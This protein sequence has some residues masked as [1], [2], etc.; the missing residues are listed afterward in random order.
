MKILKY[1]GLSCILL[2]TI[3][4]CKNWL[5][6]NTDPDNP[7]NA[8]ASLSNRLPWVQKFWQYTAGPTNFR[9]AMIAGVYYS[10]S[11]AT[12]SFGITWNCDPGSIVV[13]SYQTWFVEVASNLNDMYNKAEAEGAYHYMAASNVIHALGFMQMLDLFGEMPYTE[14]LG[15]SASPAYDDGKTIFYGCI[16]K[17]DEAIELLGRTQETGATQLSAGD[18]WGGGNTSKWIKFCYGLKARFLLKLSKKT[19]LFDANAILDCLA[20]GPQSNADNI[21]GLCYNVDGDDNDYFLSDPVNTNGNWNFA[22]YG[23]NQRISKYYYDLLTNMRGS[24]VEDPRMTKIV[25]ATMGNIKLNANGGLQSYDWI[26]SEPV[27]FYGASTRLVK[28]GPTSIQLATYANSDVTIKYPIEDATALTGF[29]TAIQGKHRYTVIPGVATSTNANPPDT[30]SVIYT[31]GSIYINSTNYIFA[32]DTAYVNLRSC[33]TLV[34]N[35]GMS[36][37]D[38]NWYY[39]TDAKAIGVIGSTGSY[40][41]RPVSDQELLTYHEMCFI[42]AEVQLRNGNSAGALTAYKKGIEAHIN[43]MQAKLTEW[44]AVGYVNNPD[45]SPMNAADIAAYLASNAVCQ[46]AGTLTMADIMLQKYLA[47]GCS[48]ENWNDMRRFNFS[49]GN[50]GSFG[51]VY[52]GYDRG[53]LFAGGAKV[54]GTSKTDPNYW[55]RRWRLPG[56]LELDYNSANASVI[57]THAGEDYVWGIP[58]WWDCATDAE[59]TGYLN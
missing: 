32:G 55:I 59:Y 11:A 50:I 52:P 21:I 43:M 16:D 4:S 15:A 23:A 7:N 28:G 3:T 58:I 9:A 26:R 45:M 46:T 34:G 19:D 27:D 54:R 37:K 40:Q 13:T 35:I 8:S 47:M 20:K 33:S 24:G 38:V 39:S 12:N 2:L 22:A 56:T 1:I 42:E 41:I 36:E 25:P 44:G 14:A 6:V 30:V 17:L 31:K 29:T 18:M 51:V 49:A 48:V 57:N 5:D 53:P 10:N